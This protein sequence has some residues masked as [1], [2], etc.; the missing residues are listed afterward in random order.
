MIIIERTSGAPFL[1][2]W[3]NAISVGRAFDLVRSDLLDH[4]RVLQREIA[5]RYCRFHAVFDDDMQVVVRRPD[6]SLAFQWRNVDQVYDA[7]LGT[8]LKP[9]VELIPMPTALASGTQTSP[10][11]KFASDTDSGLYL[12]THTGRGT[13]VG[14]VNDGRQ[15]IMVCTGRFGGADLTRTVITNEWRSSDYYLEQ[16]PLVVEFTGDWGALA[17]KKSVTAFIIGQTFNDIGGPGTSRHILPVYINGA[18][19]GI[20][21]FLN[22]E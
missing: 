9:F 15:G 20:P 6:G 22:V 19:C 1:Q 8:G 18:R 21:V 17:F 2:P 7:L 10:G 16:A 11:L 4:L 5:Y 12:A 3:R 14:I 13:G